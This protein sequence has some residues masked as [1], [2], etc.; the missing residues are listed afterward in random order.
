M[1][2]TP[3]NYFAA[4][5]FTL[6][7]HTFEEGQDVPLDVFEPDV[8][9]SLLNQGLIADKSAVQAVE[10]VEA[11]APVEKPTSKKGKATA[12]TPAE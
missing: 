1:D 2:N 12:E 8:Y 11:P 4:A 3:T 6:D 7:G 5:P 9:P 10:T